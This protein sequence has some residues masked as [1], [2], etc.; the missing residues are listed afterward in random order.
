MSHTHSTCSSDMPPFGGGE[1]GYTQ[2][3]HAYRMHTSRER[4]AWSEVRSEERAVASV[5]GAFD[6]PGF[7]FGC[8]PRRVRNDISTEH[9]EC[10]W[11]PGALVSRRLPTQP[12]GR[13]RVRDD[14]SR[15]NIPGESMGPM[16][17]VFVQ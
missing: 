1:G 10:M 12:I 7:G 4:G 17:V 16:S 3:P 9:S 6:T 2:W 8:E 14:L 15:L 13:R 5:Q 11:S